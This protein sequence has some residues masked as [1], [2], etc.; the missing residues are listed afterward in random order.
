MSSQSPTPAVAALLDGPALWH[1]L[2]HLPITTSTNDDAAGALKEGAGAGLVVVADHQTAGRGRRGRAWDDG[3]AGSSLLLTAVID[4]PARAATLLPLAAGVAVGDALRRRRIAAGLKWPN[5]ILCETGGTPRKCAGILTEQHGDHVLIGIGV[6]VDWRGVE[7][8]GEAEGWTSL[9]EALDADV[10]RWDLLVD[11][12]RALEAWIGDVARDPARLLAAY[13]VR[14]RTLG[15]EV[16]VEIPDGSVLEGTAS[17]IADD[18][19]LVVDTPAG[20][21]AVTAGD[22]EHVR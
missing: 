17:A 5:D 16:R 10:D 12:L 15:R 18:G 1:T 11:I 20:R 2:T 7:R 13:E 22:V 19:A 3:G 6:D 9:A 21:R 8:T 4:A 14:C